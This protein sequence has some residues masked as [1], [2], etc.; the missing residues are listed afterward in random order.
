MS[1][2]KEK[3]KRQKQRKHHT[4]KQREASRDTG[5]GNKGRERKICSQWE[6]KEGEGE[7]DV[8]GVPGE[9]GWFSA[10]GGNDGRELPCRLGD[11]QGQIKMVWDRDSPTQENWASCV[12]TMRFFFFFAMISPGCILRPLRDFIPF[13]RG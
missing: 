10:S 2:L 6:E 11:L 12:V 4:P 5:R 8:Q 13:C 7:L 1:R 9:G 3:K